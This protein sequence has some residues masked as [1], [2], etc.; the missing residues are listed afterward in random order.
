MALS[1]TGA[2]IPASAQRNFPSLIDAFL[3]LTEGTQSPLLF[4]RWAAAMVIA[5]A[6]ERK[7]WFKVGKRLLYP[8]LYVLL[9]GGPGIGK[10]D[11]LRGVAKYWETLP[12]LKIAPDSLSRASLI[13]SI[14]EAERSVLRPTDANPYTKFNSLQAVVAE[15]G[16]F[17]SQYDSEFLSTL[18]HLYDCIRYKESKRHMKQPIELNAPQLN[19]IA[20]TT[21]A[22]LGG[23]L[24]ETAWA[25]GFSSRLMIIY[26]GERIKVDLFADEA[27]DEA[28]EALFVEDLQKI[29]MLFG[30]MLMTPDVA[31]ALQAWY[32]LDGP[33]IPEHPKLE[34]YL[35]RR[36]VHLLKL[37]MIHSIARSNELVI[38]MVDYQEAMDMLIEAERYMPDVFK[39]MRHNSD[40]NVYD[41]IYNYVYTLFLKEN[42]PIAEHRIL[43][44][45]GMRMPTHAIP[46]ALEHM[47]NSG[48]LK[49]AAI[50]GPGGRSMYQPTPKAEHGS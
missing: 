36:H 20:A 26:S 27:T 4:R 1:T 12:E 48:M 31:A 3:D 33:P 47:T 18:N 11:A 22:W 41:E 29:H 45:I 38:R 39:A 37:C 21:P 28:A 15:F 13:D 6:L 25:E 23:T 7:V 16:T 14:N 42:K 19:L 49:V 5:G 30:P 40:A 34:H 2:P 9:T 44:F 43:H 8:S 10:T 50:G 24:P 35:P 46:K 17:L 32:M